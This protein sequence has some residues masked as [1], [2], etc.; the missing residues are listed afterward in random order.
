MEPYLFILRP[1][2]DQWMHKDIDQ[3]PLIS[4]F[5]LKLVFP[6]EGPSSCCINPVAYVLSVFLKINDC[7]IRMRVM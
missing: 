7:Y 2:L 1:Y 5:H 6:I 3:M 4:L